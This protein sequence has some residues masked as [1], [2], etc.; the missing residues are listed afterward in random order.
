MT[1]AV[2]D[3]RPSFPDKYRPGIGIIG[4]GHIVQTAHLPAYAKYGCDVAGVYDIRAEATRGAHERFGVHVYDSLDDLLGDPHVGVVDIATQPAVRVELI[5]RALAA[6]KHVLAQKPLSPD[7]GSARAVVAEAKDA[8][9]RLAVN[10]NGRWAPAWRVA[11]LLVEQGAIGDAFAVTHLL[12]KGFSFVLDFPHFD[13]FEH[14]LLYDHFVHWVDISRCWLDG[15]RPE[16]VRG[17]EFRTPPQPPETRQPWG[18]WIDIQYADGSSAA[19]RSSGGAVTSRPGCPFWI[20]GSE[21]TIRGSILLGSDFVELD[22]GGALTRFP[23][24]GE[25]YPDG[26]GGTMGELITAIAEDREPYN[27]ARHNLLTLELTFAAV[28]SAED[29]GAPVTLI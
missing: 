10:Q 3:Y 22:R 24:E 17:L 9:L 13:E 12:D 23:L 25:L 15:K 4:C 7:L 2:P 28:R 29:D 20:H 18:G 19:I 14:L 26:F 1:V 5:R 8:K 16:R 6:G 21:G 11:T 27:S